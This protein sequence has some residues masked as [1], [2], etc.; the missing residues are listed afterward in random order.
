MAQAANKPLKDSNGVNDGVMDL[1]DEKVA[2]QYAEAQE[3]F[4]TE[5]INA[6]KEGKIKYG[7]IPYNVSGFIGSVFDLAGS[8][9]HLQTPKI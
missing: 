6:V 1:S 9:N 4:I 8:E 5:T 7:V 2:K 3:L